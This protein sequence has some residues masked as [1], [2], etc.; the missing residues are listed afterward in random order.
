MAGQ[1][2]LAEFLRAR[3]ERLTPA[4]VGLPDSPRRRVKGL[5][6]EEV[7]Q[8]AGISADYYLRLEQGR[9]VH[10]S[11]QVLDA[12][13]TALRLNDHE[14]GHLADL[15]G[16]DSGRRPA[17]PTVT[18]PVSPLLTALDP[19]PA[20]AQN[21]FMDVLDAN[22][23]ARRLFPHIRPGVNLLRIAFLASDDAE[24]YSGWDGVAADA[25]AHLRSLVGAD[26]ASPRMTQLIDELSAESRTF[27]EL[28]ARGD[29]NPQPAGKR[30]LQHAEL[31][32]LE[33]EFYKL[34]VPGT[35]DVQLV[36]YF[37]ELGSET[38]AKLGLS[39]RR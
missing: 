19:L 26:V 16:V 30:Q 34:N 9:D 23:A 18:P 37:A 10:P 2:A 20:F 39:S 38:A 7:A 36:V 15:V 5:R 35:N 8:L 29:V 12:L 33:L 28:W 22:T 24:L 27:R 21:R 31:G 11:I 6:R 25:V 3:R 17:V 1:R 4:A 14:R 32:L 13:G